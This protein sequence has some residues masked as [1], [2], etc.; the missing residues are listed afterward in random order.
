MNSR[1]EK[2]EEKLIEAAEELL[3]QAKAEAV[4]IRMDEKGD[5]VVAAGDAE[6]LP[7]VIPAA[8]AK[9]PKALHEMTQEEQ[10]TFIENAPSGLRDQL[11]QRL[12]ENS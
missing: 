12:Q 3:D 7:V 2:A 8:A 10:N 6:A 4:V 9:P 11:R 5:D 1:R